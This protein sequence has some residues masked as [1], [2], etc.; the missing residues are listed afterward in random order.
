MFTI[1]RNGKKFNVE[2]KGIQS[3]V[4]IVASLRRIQL[5]V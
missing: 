1:K 5:G 3:Y 4:A 2:L